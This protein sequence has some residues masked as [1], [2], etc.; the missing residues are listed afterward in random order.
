M[1]FGLKSCES[2]SKPM[3]MVDDVILEEA[4]TTKF[5]GIH[6]DKRLTWKDQIDSVCSKVASG[7][8]A[9][10]K[11]SKYCT[12]QVQMMAYYGLIHPHLSYGITLWG[13]CAN[14]NFERV[15]RLQKRAVRILA[16]LKCRESCRE[17]FR[18]LGVLTLPCLYI[19][20]TALYC[21]YKCSLTQ[22]GDIHGY[23]T[24]AR[25]RLR[26]RQHRTVAYE[27][28]PSQAGIKFLNSLPECLR[29]EMNPRKFKARLKVHLVSLAFYT[30][31][32]FLAHRWSSMV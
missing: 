5:L 18:E 8:F 28:V 30:V 24:R 7:I 22:G 2:M 31:G 23:E 26:T 21:R 14:G 29:T 19:L 13:G 25:D 3:I 10:R 11:L 20:E 17:A 15:F 1:H 6:L 32:E 4:E 12:P 27:H 9:L 16:K